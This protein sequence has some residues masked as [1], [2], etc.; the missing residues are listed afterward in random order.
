MQQ[1]P[2][3]AKTTMKQ[4]RRIQNEENQ[5]YHHLAFLQILLFDKHKL[6]AVICMRVLNIQWQINKSYIQSKNMA[7]F[8]V[9]EKKFLNGIKN[10]SIKVKRSSA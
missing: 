9:Q 6:F 8:Q 4:L 2:D 1:L 5:N 7:N 10:A 3:V